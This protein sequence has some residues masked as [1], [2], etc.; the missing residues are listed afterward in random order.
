MFEENKLSYNAI[1]RVY[2]FKRGFARVLQLLRM[3]ICYNLLNIVFV[4][5][6]K[7][8]NIVN[9]LCLFSYVSVAITRLW[10]QHTVLINFDLGKSS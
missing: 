5:L 10:N 6:Y 4:K 9:P 7:R 1:H 8:R 3:T 2:Y